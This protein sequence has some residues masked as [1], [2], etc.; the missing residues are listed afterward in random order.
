[1]YTTEVMTCMTEHPYMA[2]PVGN[3][4]CNAEH[5]MYGCLISCQI[6]ILTSQRPTL[7]VYLKLKSLKDI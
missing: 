3:Q 5:Y 7:D 6:N 1:M 2:A 4:C